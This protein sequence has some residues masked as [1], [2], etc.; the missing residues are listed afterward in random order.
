MMIK[1]KT[2]GTLIDIVYIYANCFLYLFM[3]SMCFI[4]FSN[5]SSLKLCS[6]LQV[7]SSARFFYANRYKEI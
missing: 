1:L 7:S 5:V 4:S 2:V 6:I 3:L